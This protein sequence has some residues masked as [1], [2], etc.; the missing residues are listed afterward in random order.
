MGFAVRRGRAA[1]LATVAALTVATAWAAP[2]GAAASTA[3]PSE[4]SSAAAP[5]A[6]SGPGHAAA[7]HLPGTF[8]S[9]PP[10]RV[11]DTRSDLGAF[12][13]VTARRTITLQVTGRGGVPSSGVSAVVLNVTVTAPTKAGYITAYPGGTSRPTASNLNFTPGQTVANLVTVTVGGTGLVALTNSS[14]GRVQ[15]V[16]DVAGYYLSGTVSEPGAFVAKAPQR[17]LDTRTG[18]GAH[19]P[20]GR[21]GTISVQVLGRGGVPAS[22]VS[23]VVV[24]LTVTGPTG[25]G[26]LT[27][28]P[29]GVARPTASNLNFVKGQTVPNLATVSVPSNGRVDIYNGSSGSVHVVAD[30]A[31]YYLGGSHT[32]SAGT[33]VPIAPTRLLDT[34]IGTGAHGPVA[35]WGDVSL[36]VDGLDTV[37]DTGVAAVV[38]NVTVT[39]PTR[40]GYLTAYPGGTSRPDASNVNFLK[41]QT[42]PNLAAVQ[43]GTDGRILLANSSGG[44][45]QLV[46]DVAGYFLFDNPLPTGASVA[47]GDLH[48]CALAADGAVECWGDNAVRQV[49]A[50]PA[51]E[52]QPTATTA[53]AADARQ[54][55][56]GGSDSCALTTAGDG[57][58]GVLCWGAN[59]SGQLGDGTTTPH[60]VPRGVIGMGRA[61]V[62]VAVGDRFACGLL[63]SGSV[64]CWGLGTSGQL[65]NGTTASSA[66]PVQVRG[67]SS[68]VTGIAAGGAHA[69][70]VTSGGAVRC[71]GSGL[72]GQL[73]NGST[74]T[75]ATPVQVSG[76]T[77]GVAGIAAGGW[78]TCAVTTT[79][80]ALCWGENDEGQLGDG[81]PSV[82][83]PTP[84]PVSGLGS[85]VAG[86][87]AGG[88]HTCARMTS[89]DVRCWGEN[90]LGQLGTGS[91][92]SPVL[93]PHTVTGLGGVAT[94][95]A[96]GPGHTCASLDDGT[97]RCWGGNGSGQLGNGETMAVRTPVQVSGM[98][99]D[100]TDFSA[101]PAAC[102]GVD[103]ALRC[104]GEGGRGA[105]GNGARNDRTTPTLVSGLSTGVTAVDS[106]G[107]SCAVTSG[108]VMCWGDNTAGALGDGTTVSTA[109]PVAVSGLTSGVQSVAVGDDFSCA[110]TGVG[111][112]TCWGGNTA[113]ELGNGTTTG[114]TT[115]VA[116]TGLTSGVL[117]LTAGST[118]ACAVL[119]DGSVACWGQN[120]WGQLGDG[121]TTSSDT[122]VAVDGLPDT[123][124]AVSAGDDH[125]C[126]VTSGGAARCWGLN[127]VG[128]LGT[129]SAGGIS[130]TAV[131]VSGLTSGV[132]AVGVGGHTSCA[133][134]S[135][136]L[137]CWG[138]NTSGQLG[139]G[140][141]D[142]SAATPQPVSGMDAGVTGVS[143]GTATA[144][145]VVSG[146]LRCWG[147]RSHGDLGNGTSTAL[148]SPVTVLGF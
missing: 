54:V 12:G 5:A 70:A 101:G 1:V 75:S 33:F 140:S 78:H 39:A 132:T 2:A 130:L 64:T 81:N 22:I 94:A 135:G 35:A 115:P 147:S 82:D 38:A 87:S 129:G 59:D 92:S 74:T 30:V 121:T 112:V 145:A 41:G 32:G 36:A 18:N 73:G 8:V 10:S 119:A 98:T 42:I 100:I 48:S 44:T 52:S 69:C 83:S 97:V 68:G 89:G 19:G 23:A 63:A 139:T 91:F 86:I 111:G 104:W 13:P 9:L 72:R 3:A 67:L 134:T 11:L 4:V 37:P 6:S 95:V 34:R 90:S 110:L 148:A 117:S 103:G 141:S 131:Q 43:A 105:L 57:T 27:A 71:W 45:V 123:A 7:A 80:A 136:A 14:A 55:A 28:Y 125:A 107:H 62:Q 50:P 143:V 122:P 26:Y 113:G 47:V 108:A 31:G 76:M 88:R 102:A 66:T 127:H 15:L 24:N 53:L 118:F 51:G 21:H 144:C 120:T 84:G 138:L 29:H 60:D 133:V 128:Q 25:T 61:A 65:G 137:T 77:R 96:T 49:A 16:A 93:E 79:G 146:A 124:V 56:A 40:G 85:G 109:S 20:V 142:H 17:I 46:L 116:V 99:S 58:G 106:G 126:A 114:S